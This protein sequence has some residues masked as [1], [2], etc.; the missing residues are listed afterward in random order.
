MLKNIINK[1]RDELD[2]YVRASLRMELEP[3][4]RK[5]LRIELLLKSSSLND[6]ECS[7]ASVHKKIK[8][9]SKLIEDKSKA[10]TSETRTESEKITSTLSQAVALILKRLNS[11]Y[12]QKPSWL[13]ELSGNESKTDYSEQM[14]TCF[15][16]YIAEHSSL[17]AEKISKNID[18]STQSRLDKINDRLR[19]ELEPKISQELRDNLKNEIAEQLKSETDALLREL[20]NE[21]LIDYFKKRGW[22]EIGSF[23]D[24]LPISLRLEAKSALRNVLMPEIKRE[25]CQEMRELFVADPSHVSFQ[26]SLVSEAKEIVIKALNPVLESRIEGRIY[27]EIKEDENHPIFLKVLAKLTEEKSIRKIASDQATEN[28][29]RKLKIEISNDVH[30]PIRKLII[31]QIR[32]DSSIQRKIENEIKMETSNLLRKELRKELRNEL[33]PKVRDQLEREMLMPILVNLEGNIEGTVA[34]VLRRNLTECVDGLR[35]SIKDEVWKITVQSIAEAMAASITP[36]DYDEEDHLSDR[37]DQALELAMKVYEPKSAAARH[38]FANA[39]TTVL[40]SL[41]IG[42]TESQTDKWARYQMKACEIIDDRLLPS[43]YAVQRDLQIPDGFFRAV[44]ANQCD[45]TRSTIQ[46]GDYFVA[47]RGIR[48]G[49]PIAQNTADGLVEKTQQNGWD[50]PN[51]SIEAPWRGLPFQTQQNPEG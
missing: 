22:S 17:I 33:E 48:I 32:G 7:I 2:P 23:I 3:I 5:E 38:R 14:A 6:E 10:S 11:T 18:D 41:E 50:H 25:L 9:L 16:S 29:Q 13:P 26:G 51:E 47:F 36:P 19:S 8:S 34:S 31:E 37:I 39:L 45:L 40:R 24:H 46:P 27:T 12:D 35:E 49:L 30:H 1:L 43:K 15:E 21:T 44:K 42:P 4:I 20:E 28:I